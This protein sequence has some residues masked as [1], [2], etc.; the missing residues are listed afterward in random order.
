M[1]GSYE[2]SILRGRMS[3]T[4]SKP[5]NFVAS[6]GVLGTGSA[7]KG[8]LKCPP[9]VSVPFP[10]V[11]YSYGAGAGAVDSG[12]SPYVGLVDLENSLPHP[13]TTHRHAR[14]SR[15]SDSTT[16]TNGPRR[17][18]SPPGGCYRIPPTGQIQLIIA[19]PNKTAVKLF[20]VPYDLSD[21]PVGTK[22]FIRQRSYSTSSEPKEKDRPVLRYLVHL[23]LCCT[24]KGRYWLY[25]SVRVVFAN[26]V[27]EGEG[28][29]KEGLK[30]EV[31]FPEPRYSTYKS[32]REPAA[33]PAHDVSWSPPPQQ[34]TR[35]ELAKSL[36]AAANDFVFESA[37]PAMPTGPLP[38]FYGSRRTPEREEADGE[39]QESVSPREI[40]MATDK[41]LVF[42]RESSRERE[43]EK[44]GSGGQSLLSMRLRR[45]EGSGLDL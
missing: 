6:I 7:C 27:M 35:R 24:G 15:E 1:V 33:T 22:T 19:N 14:T 11:F 16:R 29:G 5:L 18:L 41:A 30:C 40:S 13:T 3:T 44:E 28:K 2:E 17:A 37:V 43:K 21:M 36:P 26:R 39:S 34:R 32:G 31:Q 9:H 10:A 45:E 8:G 25:K 23:N 4:P 12:P 42:G 20:L 38:Q